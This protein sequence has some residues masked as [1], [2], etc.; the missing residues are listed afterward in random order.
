MEILSFEHGI[1][2][3]IYEDRIGYWYDDDPVY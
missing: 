1:D 3:S 2:W